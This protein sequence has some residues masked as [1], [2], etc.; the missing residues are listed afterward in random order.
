[1]RAAP[2]RLGPDRPHVGEARLIRP[3]SVIRSRCL[4]ALA[5]DVVGHGNASTIEVAMSR[6]DRSRAC[7]SDEGVDLKGEVLHA[8]VGLLA[9]AS[10]PNENGW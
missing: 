10:A 1:M 2:D 6:T 4:N 8:A 7:G 5:K 9:T 3:G